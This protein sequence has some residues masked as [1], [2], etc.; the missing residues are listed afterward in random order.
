MNK[1]SIENSN[2]E[3]FISIHIYD[4]AV[5]RTGSLWG[6]GWGESKLFETSGQMFS[7]KSW[8]K[9]SRRSMTWQRK[10]GKSESKSRSIHLHP[11]CGRN[12][13]FEPWFGR[14]E[15]GDLEKTQKF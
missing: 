2:I 14:K 1:G 15:R 7:R 10:E 4:A 3:L 13:T 12:G 6:V 9:V 8:M 11:K 5:P